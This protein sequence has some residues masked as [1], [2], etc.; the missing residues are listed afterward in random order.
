MSEWN[1]RIRLSAVHPLLPVQTAWAHLR[2]VDS[3]C[4]FAARA[5][6]FCVLYAEHSMAM[7]FTDDFQKA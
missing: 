7:E 3:E 5:C 4:V 2:G 1:R 6:S